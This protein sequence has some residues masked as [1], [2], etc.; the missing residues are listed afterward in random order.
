MTNEIFEE[1]KAEHINNIKQYIKK[2]GNMFSQITVIGENKVIIEKEDTKP[3][4]IIIPIPEEALESDK[5]KE[6]FINDMLPEIFAKIQEEFIPKATIWV[7]EAWM[8]STTKN[9]DFDKEDY[10][11]LPISKEVLFIVVETIDKSETIIFDIKRSGVQVN[12]E[13]KMIDTIDLIPIP[14]YTQEPNLLSG[15][16]SNLF[17]IFKTS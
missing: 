15:R 13:G 1:I 8:R 6:T 12:N 11:K 3:A 2:E 17:K 4:I 7:A 5:N 10:K 16:F 14:E 9:F